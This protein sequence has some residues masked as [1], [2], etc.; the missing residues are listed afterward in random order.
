MENTIIPALLMFRDWFLALTPLQLGVAAGLLQILGY[1]FYIRKTLRNEV[2]PNPAT[3]LMFAYGTTLLTILEF[4]VGAEWHLLF[5]PVA[6]AIL[7]VYVAFLCW[8]RGTLSWPKDREDQIAFIADLCLT[9]I[10]VTAGILL[11]RG[12]ISEESRTLLSFVL[13]FASNATAITAFTPLIRGA[14]ANPHREHPYAWVAWTFAYLLLA[15]AT[16]REHKAGELTEFSLP[17]VGGTLH[18]EIDLV[19]VSLMVYP[20]LNAVLHGAV[21]VLSRKRRKKRHPR[22][23]AA[24]GE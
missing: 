11:W 10:Y 14:I 22:S 15:D 18:F 17:F 12:A 23:V 7:G 13:L 8:H 6:C 1:T 9:A 16:Y 20:V 19:L 21:A 2:E 5:L 4:D 24:A 3:W